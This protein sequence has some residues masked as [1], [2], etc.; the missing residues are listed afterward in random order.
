MVKELQQEN[1]KLNARLVDLEH[2]LQE[3][4]RVQEEM[5]S[6]A[7]VA[8]AAEFPAV[9]M[10][11]ILSEPAAAVSEKPVQE[12]AV[13]MAPLQLQADPHYEVPQF[14]RV[15]RSERHPS[16]AKKKPFLWTIWSRLRT[17]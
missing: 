4:R 11:A 9:H 17:S 14:I 10:P 5:S 7:Q 16:P 2:Q 6:M 15:S 8:A 13:K 12:A 1:V 3:A